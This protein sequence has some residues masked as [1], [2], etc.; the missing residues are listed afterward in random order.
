MAISKGKSDITLSAENANKK[1][2][3][4]QKYVDYFNKNNK[5]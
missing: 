5:I 4:I 3:I 2:K 1:K